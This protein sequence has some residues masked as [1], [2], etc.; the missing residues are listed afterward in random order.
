MGGVQGARHWECILR[1]EN[2]DNSLKIYI[3]GD[4]TFA[5]ATIAPTKLTTK[6][7][8]EGNDWVFVSG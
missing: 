7:L 5:P 3:S 2:N 6:S 4:L 8:S 1:G